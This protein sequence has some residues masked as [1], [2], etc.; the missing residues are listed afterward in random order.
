MFSPR[1]QEALAEMAGGEAPDRGR[2]CGHCYTPLAGDDRVCPHCSTDTSRRPPVE[3]LPAEVIEMFR[4]L[5]RHERMGGKSMAVLGLGL[6]AALFLGLFLVSG[7]LWWRIVDLVIL[8]VASRLFAG[9]LGGA[10]GDEVGR[11]FAQ[12]RLAREWWGFTQRREGA[13]PQGQ[14]PRTGP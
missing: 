1:L 10:F 14:E 11:R 13:G 8:V 7:A 12:R 2:F 4:A 6:G 9:I 5:R 3:Q